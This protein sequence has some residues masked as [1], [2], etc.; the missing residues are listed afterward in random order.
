MY[1]LIGLNEE[2]HPVPCVPIPFD[3]AGLGSS[4]LTSPEQLMFM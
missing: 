4:P 3:H 2:N 1:F